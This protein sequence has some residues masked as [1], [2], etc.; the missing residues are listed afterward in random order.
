MPKQAEA[1][2]DGVIN[3]QNYNF[4][5]F[6]HGKFCK[7]S[8]TLLVGTPASY[9]D[10][11]LSIGRDGQLHTSIYDNRDDF[12]FHIS[13]FPFLSSIP[14]SPAYGVFISQLYD[15]PGLAPRMNVFF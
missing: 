3:P 7:F 11:L 1:K 9:L 14:S 15:T 6:Y 8:L 12:N 2:R 10:L 13:N 5:Q 4:H